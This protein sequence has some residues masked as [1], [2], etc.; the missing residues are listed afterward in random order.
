LSDLFNGF[1][2]TLNEARVRMGLSGLDHVMDL[3]DRPERVLFAISRAF[4][5]E[6][7]LLPDNVR[8]VGPLLDE[9]GWSKAWQA[10]WGAR[11]ELPR[12]LVTCSS[13]AQGQRDLVQRVIGA[14]GTIEIDAVVTTG[15]NLNV[16]DL[17]APKNVHLLRAA[18]HDAVMKD[19]S[20]VVT[21]GGHGTVCRALI[22]GVPQL[23]LPNGRDQD[24]NAARV[25]ARGAGLRLPPT[26]SETE[27]AAAVKRLI[28]ESRFRAS[29]CRLG[30]A[31]KAEIG[32]SSLVREMEA[33]VGARREAE[34]GMRRRR[35][36]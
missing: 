22:N 20:L 30:N 36:A 32:E 13:G 27:I 11:S 34:F 4:D 2:P 15:P 29:A 10:P 14:M 35:L 19:V 9:P 5:F 7:D 28:R 1:L 25:E 17:R 16:T 3:F 21:Q 31:M 33:I 12:A 6:A 23:I 24:D 18:P 8:Y 26:A